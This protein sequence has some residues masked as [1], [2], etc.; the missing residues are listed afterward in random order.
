VAAGTC[1]V[2]VE[3][4]D[5]EAVCLSDKARIFC[6]ELGQANVA[7]WWR[8]QESRKIKLELV[9]RADHDMEV[10]LAAA[11]QMLEL[12]LKKLVKSCLVD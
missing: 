8:F 9:V 11:R 2:T 6:V 5:I 10:C 1:A 7:V 12:S 3:D 4:V